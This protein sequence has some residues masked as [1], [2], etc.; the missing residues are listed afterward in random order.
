M[1]SNLRMFAQAPGSE[2]GGLG[3]S[4][5][6]YISGGGF[7]GWI[8]VALSVVALTLVVIHAVQIRRTTLLPAV[9]VASIRDLLGAGRAEEALEY[10]LIAKIVNGAGEIG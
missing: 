8:I 4:L 3:P 9:Q 6:T 10:G 2:G 7:I 5:L 1:N